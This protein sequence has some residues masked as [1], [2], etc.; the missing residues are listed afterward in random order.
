MYCRRC[1]N[2]RCVFNHCYY[3]FSPLFYHLQHGFL[4]GRSTVTQLLEVYYNILDSV[5]SGKRVDIIYLDLS[6]AF[7]KVPHSL[8]LLK[9]NR[10]GISGSLLSW[11]N[12]YLADRYQRVVL[13]GVHSDWLPITSGVPQ[14]SILGPLLFLVYV[15]DL[16]SYI[17]SRSSIVLFAD[18][19]KLYNSI[20]LPDSTLYLQN[21]LDNIHKWSLDWAMKFNESKCQVL[22]ISRKKTKTVAEYYL[23][24]NDISWSRHIEEMVAKANRI[25]GLVKRTCKDTHDVRV[26]KLLFCALVRPIL[27]YASNLWSPYTIKH[28]SLVENVQRRATKFIL[29]Y[30]KT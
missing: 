27:E 16:P 30:P 28:K 15:N 21:D 9:L 10:F 1:W 11:F 17:N 25:L 14:D 13:D 29:N 3:H 18:D 24:G 4:R 8:L 12:S 20:D 5:A 26:R 19:S 22:R 6:K 23:D 2:V 7:D